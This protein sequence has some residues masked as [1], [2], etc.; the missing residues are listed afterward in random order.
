MRLLS[1]V[2]TTSNVAVSPFDTTLSAISFEIVIAESLT[3]NT[4]GV[5]STVVPFLEV[6]AHL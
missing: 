6:T 2:A 5:V 1:A 3:S 4:D